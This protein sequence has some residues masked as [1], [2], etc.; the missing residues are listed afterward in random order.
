VPLPPVHLLQYLIIVLP[1]VLP[2]VWHCPVTQ[3][4]L[5]LLAG[6]LNLPRQAPLICC[7][8]RLLH[9]CFNGRC[10]RQQTLLLLLLPAAGA[11][12]T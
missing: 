6:M 9:C 3:L 2:S 12:V 10:L 5:L 4:S 8:C 1:R 7:T 11:C